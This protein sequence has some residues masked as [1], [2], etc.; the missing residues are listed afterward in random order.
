MRKGFTLIELLVVIAIIA[1]L[2]AILFPV[3]ARAR[4][5]AR[6]TKCLSNLKQIAVAYMSYAQDYDEWF[7]GART[8]ASVRYPWYA[9]IEPYS[10]NSQIY[11]CPSTKYRYAP[12]FNST[13][14]Y[15]S[16]TSYGYYMPTI[17]NPT[18]KFM[19]M[20][21]A[22][23][24]YAHTLGDRDCCSWG[25]YIHNDFIYGCRGHMWPA[26]NEMANVAFCDGHAKVTPLNADTLGNNMPGR[27]KYWIGATE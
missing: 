12:N 22:G 6:A 7:P 19:T 4:E 27:N 26:H 23:D 20:D 1:I 18:E 9:I 10:K 2:A 3:F 16:S 11:I 21:A 8:G 17:P 24:D 13:T 14:T 25:P 15:S 5:K